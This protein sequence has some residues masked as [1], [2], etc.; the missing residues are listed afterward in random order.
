MTVVVYSVYLQSTWINLQF[1]DNTIYKFFFI[2]EFYFYPTTAIT[3]NEIIKMI[4]GIVEKQVKP[5][6]AD[7]RPGDVKH[8]LADITSAQ[9]IIGFKAIISFEEG[10]QKAIEWYRDNLL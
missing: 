10:L 3:I 5:I 8:S 1:I 6:Y 9:N 7:P 4:N 2:F